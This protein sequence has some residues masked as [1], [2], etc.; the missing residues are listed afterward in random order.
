MWE[1]IYILEIVNQTISLSLHDFHQYDFSWLL[2]CIEWHGYLTQL[3]VIFHNLVIHYH[4]Q[5]FWNS[6]S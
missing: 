4:S 2:V 3:V 1:S 6:T 5:C